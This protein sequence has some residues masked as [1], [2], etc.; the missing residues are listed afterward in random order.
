MALTALFDT[1]VVIAGPVVT[2]PEELVAG[3][4]AVS[5]VT[6]GELEAGVLS[7]REPAARARRL[8]VLLGVAADTGV[9]GIDRAV[10]S[11][12]ARIRSATGRQPSNDL[13]IAATALAHGLVLVTAD[14][15]QAQLPLVESVHVG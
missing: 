3:R 15:R 8:A 9:L 2:V 13:W 11:A 10:A 5:S 4:W 12:Y 6:L 1:S 7:A 14:E